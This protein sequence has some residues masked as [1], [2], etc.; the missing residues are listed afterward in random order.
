MND[1]QTRMIQRLAMRGTLTMKL[2]LRPKVLRRYSHDGY[3]TTTEYASIPTPVWVLHLARPTRGAWSSNVRWFL[4]VLGWDHV[5]VE[6]ED[7]DAALRDAL[8]KSEPRYE[9]LDER[10]DEH[11]WFC[12]LF[13]LM[14]SFR[15]WATHV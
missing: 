14:D 2:D 3:G 11:R 15:P 13:D 12:G 6:D 7:L 9:P 10:V 8:A 4:N 5:H 1:V